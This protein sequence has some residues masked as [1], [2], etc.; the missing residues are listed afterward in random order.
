MG[1]G[2]PFPAAAL[3]YRVELSS[4]FRADDHAIQ[5]PGLGYGAGTEGT[6]TVTH[7]LLE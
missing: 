3:G 7:G 1:E 6:S 2:G 5:C 4:E